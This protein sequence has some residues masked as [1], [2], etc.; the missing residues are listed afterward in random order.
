MNFAFRHLRHLFVT[1]FRHPLRIDYKHDAKRVTEV[2]EKKQ[3][4]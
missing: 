3:I 1:P 2:T 4:F